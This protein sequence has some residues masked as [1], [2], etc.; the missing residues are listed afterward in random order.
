MKTNAE[1]FNWDG[2]EFPVQVD[3]IN[4]FEKKNPKYGVNV[5][6]YKNEKRNSTKDREMDN[7]HADVDFELVYQPGKDEQDPLDFLS[8]HPLPS[9]EEEE[10]EAIIKQV[11]E[12]SHAIVLDKIREE[13]AKDEQL[14]K[15]SERMI[16]GD[17][18][19]HRKDPDITPYFHIRQEL[20]EVDGIILRDNKIVVPATL[21][22]KV[23][24]TAHRL[25]H[26]GITKTKQMLREKYWFPTMNNLVEQIIGQCFECQVT[27][28]SHREEPIKSR[29]IPREPWET[30]AID[31]GGPYPDGHY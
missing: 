2:I 8:R 19:R 9:N 4:I 20:Y 22:R 1:K 25:G 28:K 13:T 14:Q 3:K 17:W 5:Y 27:V 29:T 12:A 30:I 10:T 16:K 23:V 15:L 31:F 6:G 24:K 11:T 7:E 26:L 18:A 21:Q